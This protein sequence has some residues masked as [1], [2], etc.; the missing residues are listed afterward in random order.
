MCKIEVA[1]SCLNEDVFKAIDR[2]KRIFLRNEYENKVFVHVLHQINNGKRYESVSEEII[3]IPGVRY[4]RLDKIGLPFSRN[5]AL[6]NC[7]SD[8]LIPTDA[9]VYLNDDFYSIVESSF[10]KY[11]DADFITFKSYFDLDYNN[12]RKIFKD[13]SYKHNWRTLLSVSSIE[14]VLDV[15]KFKDKNI[16]WDKDFGLGAKW[17]GGLETVMLQNA[18]SSDAIGYY[19]PEPISSH[20]EVSSGSEVSLSRVKLRTA[21]FLRCFGPAIGRGFSLYYHFYSDMRFIK[22]Y[23]YFN[24]LKNIFSL[25]YREI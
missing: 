13:F 20:E 15:K 22:S 14:I 5:F 1:I 11:N 4:S 21:V 7:K 6:L 3:N 10:R 9:D 2:A 19:V 18:N 23:G 17:P 12:P 16:L 24:V 25:R 8:Y